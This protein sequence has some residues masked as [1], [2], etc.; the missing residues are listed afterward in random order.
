MAARIHQV[1]LKVVET[2]NLNCSYCYMYHHADQSY[3]DRPGVMSEA[4]YLRTMLMLRSYCERHDS[5][6]RLSFHGGEP[7]LLGK[8]R[9]AEWV[10]H[11]HKILGSLIDAISIQTNGTLIDEDWIQIFKRFR[12]S[13][14]VSVD[15]PAWIHDQARVDH[16]GNGSHEKVVSGL[17]YMRRARMPFTVLCVINPRVPGLAVYQ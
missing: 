7:T 2:C 13:V 5:S 3:R 9:F 15:G 8:K 1:I 14:G 6:I 11:A 16:R 17:N 12:V 4:V 10:F